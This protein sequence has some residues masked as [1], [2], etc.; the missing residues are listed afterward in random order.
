M[1]H[2][3][4]KPD[5]WVMD[6]LGSIYFHNGKGFLKLS[7]AWYLSSLSDQT[8]ATDIINRFP[9]FFDPATGTEGP[10]NYER[11]KIKFTCGKK[12]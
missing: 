11:C 4:I 3:K 12:T 8:K 6:D 7:K 2:H 1:I 10:D 9:D 5:V